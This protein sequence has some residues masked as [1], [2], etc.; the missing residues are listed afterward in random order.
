ME[1]IS[2][3]G[4]ARGGAVIAGARGF[5]AFLMT[6]SESNAVVL[7]RC[8]YPA[9]ARADSPTGSTACLGPPPAGSP[10]GGGRG[11]FRA[12][13]LRGAGEHSLVGG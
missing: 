8:P 6:G 5:V 13:C 7:V 11:S 3:A 1:V 10:P 12:G 4:S 9:Y 2:I